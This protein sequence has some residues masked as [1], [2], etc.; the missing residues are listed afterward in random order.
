[1]LHQN[2]P[3]PS[4]LGI[5]ESA[6]VPRGWFG[7]LRPARRPSRTSNFLDW[8][9]DGTP[10][11]A[12]LQAASDASYLKRGW[13][14][15]LSPGHPDALDQIDLLL[16]DGVSSLGDGRVPLLV[17]GECS[18]L[19]CGTIS[20]RVEHTDNEVRWLGLGYQT[21]RRAPDLFEPA[22]DVTFGRP[23]Y[24]RVLVELR[25]RFAAPA[26]R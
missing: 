6:Y 25:M 11:L 2:R 22:I 24:E 13:T 4:V 3:M 26:D 10:L 5:A 14:T 20:T 15:D 7:R 1:M 8:V 16:G 12:R 19:W 9:I 17:C 18:D 23:P 21:P